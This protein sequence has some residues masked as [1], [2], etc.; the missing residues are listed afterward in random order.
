MLEQFLSTIFDGFGSN[1]GAIVVSG[2]NVFFICLSVYG[3]G[4]GGLQSRSSDMEVNAICLFKSAD[5][6]SLLNNCKP[7]M[8]VNGHFLLFS[9]PFKFKL[10]PPNFDNRCFLYSISSST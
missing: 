7:K 10:S 1:F 3:G 5:F 9:L 6:Y 4:G 2:S 8:K